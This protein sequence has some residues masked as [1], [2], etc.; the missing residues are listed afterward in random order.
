MMLF[1]RNKL[2]LFGGPRLLAT[3]QEVGAAGNVDRQPPAP[4]CKNR[5]S[6]M[7]SMNSTSGASVNKAIVCIKS[8]PRDLVTFKEPAPQ[9]TL[10]LSVPQINGAPALIR[11]RWWDLERIVA[12]KYHGS[13]AM[14]HQADEKVVPA[15]CPSPSPWSRQKVWSGQKKF[16]KARGTSSIFRKMKKVLHVILGSLRSYNFLSANLNF[17]WK[18]VESLQQRQ[19]GGKPASL[20]RSFQPT[21]S[22]SGPPAEVFS[23]CSLLTCDKQRTKIWRS[24]WW[25]G[26]VWTNTTGYFEFSVPTETDRNSSKKQRPT[27]NRSSGQWKLIASRRQT[28]TSAR[29]I[30]MTSLRFSMQKCSRK[31]VFIWKEIF[32]LASTILLIRC[33][34]EKSTKC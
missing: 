6:R 2:L 10:H 9:L 24:S 1:H 33:L 25:N 28:L 15:I 27:S 11:E 3:K 17:L 16:L 20:S 7:R 30:R 8:A 29:K 32:R 31:V 26:G 19:R 18:T 5:P 23:Y 22:Q 13:L 34:N 4:N 14:R 21:K 12:N